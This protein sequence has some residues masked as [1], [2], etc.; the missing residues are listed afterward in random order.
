VL[1]F[2]SSGGT[3]LTWGLGQIS[4]R[5]VVRD[6]VVCAAPILPVSLTFDHRVLDGALAAEIVA[7]LKN[8]LENVHTGLLAAGP[9]A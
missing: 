2:F 7:A 4:S 8:T 9:V 3:A 6:D 1:R 5:P